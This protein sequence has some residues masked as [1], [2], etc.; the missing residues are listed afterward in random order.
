[1][2]TLDKAT[3]EIYAHIEN[4][5]RDR[6][7]QGLNTT[8]NKEMVVKGI[9]EVSLKNKYWRGVTSLYKYDSKLFIESLELLDNSAFKIIL[10]VCVKFN[11]AENFFIYDF[12]NFGS[13]GYQH[14]LVIAAALNN[15]SKSGTS[16]KPVILE[17][18]EIISFL[19]KIKDNVNI[20]NKK[21]SFLVEEETHW[22]V[23]EILFT[24]A[25]VRLFIIDSLGPRKAKYNYGF[26]FIQSFLWKHFAGR[27]S[28]QLSE[29]VAQ[30]ST[31][32]CQ[33]FAIDYLRKLN[34]MPESFALLPDPTHMEST[35]ALPITLMRTAQLSNLTEQI[36]EHAEYNPVQVI[37]KKGQTIDE[38]IQSHLR[39]EDIKGSTRLSNRYLE[40]KHAMLFQ[41]VIPYLNE[42]TAEQ[43]K[44]AQREFTMQ[45]F[46]ERI[47]RKPVLS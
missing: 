15:K 37:N 40:H 20:L 29:L 27:F 19:S 34:R 42:T 9:I 6:N 24:P 16:F 25:K 18:T 23:G 28:I 11:F 4:F 41:K 45:G 17:Y 30:N 31:G 38:A 43:R 26:Q 8:D 12:A 3:Q 22:F 44:H 5:I 13:L 35:V 47:N 39:P 14:A 32:T 36:H 10:R 2:P 1:M 7:W 33:M 46:I 21:I